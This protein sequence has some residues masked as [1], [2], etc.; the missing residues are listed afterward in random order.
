MREILDALKSAT[1]AVSQASSDAKAAR[2]AAHQAIAAANDASAREREAKDD[3]GFDEAVEAAQAEQAR[4][5]ALDEPSADEI[6][7]ESEL[8]KALGGLSHR[9]E[10]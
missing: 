1:E 7:L 10:E 4:I 9:G 8:H 6:A 5:L 2:D 3:A